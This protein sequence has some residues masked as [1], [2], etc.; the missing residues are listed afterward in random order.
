MQFLETLIA[1]RLTLICVEWL[2]SGEIYQ[3]GNGEVLKDSTRK[4]ATAIYNF[5]QMENVSGKDLIL[6]F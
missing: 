5:A 6:V 1:L 2:S 3:K 4:A